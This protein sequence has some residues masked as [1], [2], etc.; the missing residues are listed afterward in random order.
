MYII[1]ES[2]SEID[3]RVVPEIEYLDQYKHWFS[4]VAY[5]APENEHKVVLST[6]AHRVVSEEIARACKF[7]SADHLDKL[8]IAEGSEIHEELVFASMEPHSYKPKVYYTLTEQDKQHALQFL[9]EEMYIALEMYYRDVLTEDQRI[10]HQT[11][12]QQI[13]TEIDQLTSVIDAKRMIHTKFGTATSS[14][15][16]QE[17]S[18]GPTELNLT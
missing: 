12:R 5:I 10:A 13:L 3:P 6:I 11:K 2:L 18:W 4:E 15:L 17:Y 7:A 9:K 8:G 16:A 14:V 1:L